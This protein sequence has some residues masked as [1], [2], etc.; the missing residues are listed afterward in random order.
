MIIVCI[1]S[2]MLCVNMQVD[3]IDFN[4]YH[5]PL[6]RATELDPC[7]EYK[8]EIEKLRKEN[9]EMLQFLRSYKQK[10]EEVVKEN[11]TLKMKLRRVDLID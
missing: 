7:E 5:L 10:Y 1:F 11:L 2:D 8:E 3:A 6:A 4:L 9:A